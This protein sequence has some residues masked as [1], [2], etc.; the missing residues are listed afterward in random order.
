MAET[1]LTID[2]ICYVVDSG[3]CKQNSF[4]PR[5][6]MDSL[7]VTPIS[8]VQFSFHFDPRLLQIKEKVVQV[9]LEMVIVSDSTQSLPM[10]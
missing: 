9:V 7:I 10:M 4:N 8:Q 5:T 1:S 2:N 6:G 3:L